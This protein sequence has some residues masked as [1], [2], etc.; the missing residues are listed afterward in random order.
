[1]QKEFKG[2][3]G[4]SVKVRLAGAGAKTVVLVGLG[5]SSALKPSSLAGVCARS[6]IVYMH[7]DSISIV[8]LVQAL[9]LHMPVETTSRPGLHLSA[10]SNSLFFIVQIGSTLASEAKA[11]KPKTVAVVL[12]SQ[13][14]TYLIS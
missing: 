5:K 6:S 3:A 14:G 1:V 13:A 12:P 2:K 4:S 11:E 7:S 9:C 10:L 8:S